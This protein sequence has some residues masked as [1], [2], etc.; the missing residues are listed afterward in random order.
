MFDLFKRKPADEPADARP[1]SERL[2]SGLSLSRERLAGSLAGVFSRRKLDDDALEA[3]ES[4]LLMADVGVAATAHLIE[5]LNARYRRAGPDASLR[6]VLRDSLTSLIEPLEAPLVV[7]SVRPFVIMLAG[8]NGAGKT[9]SI[10]K[11]AKWLQQQDLSVLLAAGDTFRAAAREQLAVWGERNNIAVIRQES[12]DPAAVMFDALGAAH[13][14]QIDV[15]L[16]DTA[17]RLP[18]QG[19]LMEE[20]AKIKRVIAKARPG[21]PDEVLLVLD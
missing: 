10:G 11:L 15:V 16:A 1:W 20:L 2:K 5:D 17:G 13:A 19:Q 6:S 7:S 3:L 9:T 12:G 14:R 8:V 4:A 18:T 21:A